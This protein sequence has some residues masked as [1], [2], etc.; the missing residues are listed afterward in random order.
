VLALRFVSVDLITKNI[1]MEKTSLQI[2]LEQIVLK[3]VKGSVYL[4]PAITDLQIEEALKKEKEQMCKMYV[5]GRNDN[6][7][8]YY[9][10]KHAKET[11]DEFFVRGEQNEC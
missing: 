11:Y 8:D 5:Q 7:L 4:I 10:E 6:H 1:N 9:P 2:F 3:Q